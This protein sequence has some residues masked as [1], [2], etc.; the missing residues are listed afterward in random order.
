M[1]KK[2]YCVKFK[3]KQQGRYFWLFLVICCT[4][5]QALFERALIHS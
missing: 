5:K 3:A 4:S 1:F 2:S